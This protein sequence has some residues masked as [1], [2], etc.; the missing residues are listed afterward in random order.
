MS[1]TLNNLKDSEFEDFCYDLLQSMDFVNLSWR[2]GT[3]LSS[4]PSDQGRDIQGKLL[5]TDIDGS[6]HHEQWFIE[7][8]HYMK[9]VPPEKLQS[10]LAWANSKDPMFC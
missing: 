1:F 3:G 2:K 5:R 10:A 7:C 6:Q 8:K 4:S 9:G